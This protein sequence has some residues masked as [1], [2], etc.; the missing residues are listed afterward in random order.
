MTHSKPHVIG[1]IPARYASKRLTGKPLIDLYGKPMVQHTYERASRAKSLDA[2]LVATDDGRIYQAVKQFGGTAVMTPT[3]CNSGSDRI[4][5][6]L[7]EMFDTDIV[8]NIQVDEPLLAPEMIDDAVRALTEDKAIQVATLVKRITDPSDLRNMNIPKVVLDKENFALYFSR[9]II[10]SPRDDGNA[11]EWLRKR[12][13]YKHIGL[14]VYRREFLIKF[15]EMEPT[16]LEEVEQ[17]EQLRILENGYRIKCTITDR[18]S[19]SVDTPK[20]LERIR[21]L[22]KEK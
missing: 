14:Y 5:Y 9:A 17:L 1:V 22:I 16:T 3:T 2:V 21:E 10:P 12:V 7:R 6:V 8:V 11:H 15:S 13:Y 20:D 4:A 18:E 19:I